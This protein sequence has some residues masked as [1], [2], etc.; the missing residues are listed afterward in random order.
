MAILRGA[1]MLPFRFRSVNQDTKD[2][3]SER[4]CDG[5]M[6]KAA[7]KLVRN[8][9]GGPGIDDIT[10]D[11]FRSDC[12][13]QIA[14]LGAQLSAGR[15]RFSRLRSAAIPKADGDRRMLGIPTV[16]DRVVLQ[17]IRLTLEPECEKKFH[18]ASH[19]YR[20]SRGAETAMR[21]LAA[22]MS[23]GMCFVA[24]T[25]I[26]KF[27][28]NVRHR[29]VLETLQWVAPNYAA[30]PLLNA[31]MKIS[32]GRWPASKGLAQGSPL[33]PLLANVALLDFDR[34]VAA[35]GST[36]IRYADDLILLASSRREAERS[37]ATAQKTL[38]Q[39]GLELHPGKT[40]ILDSRQEEFD[41]LGFRFQPDR[42]S[43]TAENWKRLH[44]E[45][46]HWCDP[47]LE[48]TWPE[49][50]DRINGLMRS[51][52]WYY[53]KADCGRMLWNLDHFVREQLE[54]LQERIGK[55]DLPWEQKIVNVSRLRETQ[56]NGKIS[57]SRRWNGYG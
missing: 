17:A 53:Q 15:F 30:S 34:V 54:L 25:D 42:V 14:R 36:L 2:S 23:E 57:R 38:Q 4:V 22:A 50:I 12:D 29:T 52:A 16:Q 51:F 18:P 5:T 35:S 8:A 20:P 48:L 56:Q 10:I 44:E 9:D 24:E 37:L 19:A 40:R 39:I 45:I 7:W 3:L 27:F 11:A 46:R 32:P 28:D 47:K 26:R 31:A 1:M 33:S 13:T 49:R 41:F 6:L 21:S 55:P 43:P